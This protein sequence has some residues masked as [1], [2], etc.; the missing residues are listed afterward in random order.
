[1]FHSRNWV[2]TIVFRRFRIKHQ[3]LSRIYW[4][5][6]MGS[7][8][9]LQLISGKTITNFA[10]DSVSS[11]FPRNMLPLSIDEMSLWIPDY[12]NRVRLHL[13]VVASANLEAY[14]K[15]ATTIHLCAKGYS[16]SIG[17]LND[18]GK[19]LGAPI[20]DKNT[21][22][23]PLKYAQSLFAVNLGTHLA[24]WQE[25]YKF[26]S[27]MAHNGGYVT[28]RTLREIPSLKQP[29]NTP[30]Q[31]SWN[32]LKEYLSSADEIASLID[33]KIA[34][35]EV[36]AIEAEIELTELKEAGHL[37]NRK[38][39]WGVLHK[40]FGLIVPKKYKE[41]MERRIYSK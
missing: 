31:L 34:T 20:L 6:V 12:L 25:A 36:Q 13:L 37:P 22:P 40:Q 27:A 10:V 15:N 5:H 32:A 19:A 11:S 18:V 21:L 33:M 26:R 38:G 30:I 28:P 24:N 17:K 4:T 7:D 2:S 41:P 3:E 14:L 23:D 8:A 9:I 1:M 35:T 39:V 16:E 29:L